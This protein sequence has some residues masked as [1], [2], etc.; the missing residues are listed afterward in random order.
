MVVFI[1]VSKGEY[2]FRSVFLGLAGVYIAYAF[3]DV[4]GEHPAFRPRL[5][6]ALSL[7]CAGLIFYGR[8]SFEECS[9]A[10]SQISTVDGS[11]E[12][13]LPLQGANHDE[14]MDQF[15][16]RCSPNTRFVGRSILC[17]FQLRNLH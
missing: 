12:I 15:L 16:M 11:P 2:R 14:E 9:R 17:R 7:L 4:C 3:R 13:A 10:T 6:V 8:C 1:K 5:V